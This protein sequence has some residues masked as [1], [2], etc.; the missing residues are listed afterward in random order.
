MAW[1]GPATTALSSSRVLTSTPSMRRAS[2]PNG[3]F[4]AS[5]T[6]ACS[7]RSAVDTSLVQAWS[8]RRSAFFSAVVVG[9]DQAMDLRR[10]RHVTV[11]DVDNDDDV[12]ANLASASRLGS[13]VAREPVSYT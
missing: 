10:T 9:P 8:I 1:S 12:E 4:V 6:S 13:K 3:A 11:D 5:A 2:A 7:A